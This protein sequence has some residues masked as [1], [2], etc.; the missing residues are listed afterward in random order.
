MS[1]QVAIVTPVFDDWDA[2]AALIVEIARRFDGGDIAFHVIAVDDGSSAT[3]GP[4]STAIPANGC[5]AEVEV[6]RLALNLGHQ[7][8]IATGL[9]AVADRRDIDAVI[10]MDCDGEDRPE[11]IAAL[12]DASRRDP[13]R[14]VLAHRSKR[15][16]SR[17]FRLGYAVYKLLFHALTGRV[18]SFGNYALLPIKA[19]RRLVHMPE[20]WNNL[21]AAIM[22]SRVPY[23]TVPTERG[24]RYA[25]QSKM[26]LVSLVVHG[27]SAMSVYT[28]M[29]FVRTLI[30]A[31][32]IAGL[33]MLGI[34]VVILIRFVTDLAVP[35]WATNVVGNL[36]IVLLQT[37]VIVIATS[38]MMLSG[39]SNRPIVPIIDAWSFVAERQQRPRD[40]GAVTPARPRALP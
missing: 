14:I 10:V 12:C 7:R 18:I 33:S 34:I 9:C 38:L 19:V 4:A 24:K 28:D 15:S 23:I 32:V 16:E 31:A 27:L 13:G 3:P 36:L 22:R 8:A 17:G 29:I 5:V 2:F 37:V 21:P 11:D 39:R 1:Q 20:L 30:A 25:G 40:H 35:G 26:N 6:L